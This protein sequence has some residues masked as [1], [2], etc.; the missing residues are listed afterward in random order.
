MLFL[1]C[2]KSLILPL[3]DLLCFIL[4][5]EKREFRIRAET[6]VNEPTAG[7]GPPDVRVFV[8]GQKCMPSFNHILLLSYIVIPLRHKDLKYMM[9]RIPAESSCISRLRHSKRKH[10]ATSGPVLNAF[11]LPGLDFSLEEHWQLCLCSWGGATFLK[12]QQLLSFPLLKRQEA[13]HSC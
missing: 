3:L 8:S 6:A 5:A 4:T 7:G 11:L 12:P 10:R 1:S 13:V 9:M 2:T